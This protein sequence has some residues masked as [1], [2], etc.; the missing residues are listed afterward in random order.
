VST[1]DIAARS[2]AVLRQLNSRAVL[3]VLKRS[4]APLRVAEIMKVTNLSRPT[5]ETVT[6]GLLDQGWLTVD[7]PQRISDGRAGRPARRYSFNA[8]AGHVIGVDIGAHSVAVSLAG[9]RGD[10]IRTIR[11]PVSPN[12]SARQRVTATADAVGEILE[13]TKVHSDT[14]FA[15]TVGTPGTVSPSNQRVGKSP[16][17]PG[18]SETDLIA[19][20][21]DLA[22]FDIELEND[23]NLAAV[24]ERARGIGQGC[25]NM[26]FLLL[27]QRLGAGVIA[28]GA[29]IRGRDGAAGELGYAPAARARAR[30]AG[31][32]PLESLVN[33]RALVELGQRAIA[34][35]PNSRLA[36]LCG[37]DPDQLTAEAITLAAAEGDAAATRVL[38]TLV[39][40]LAQGIAPALLTLNPEVLVLGGGRSRA[41]EVLRDSLRSEINE[42]VLYPP[43]IRTSAL[44]DEAVLV[45]ALDESIKRV[46][47]NVL[48]KVSA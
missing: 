15:V 8:T 22:N 13:I 33:A 16:G 47:L 23:A 37:H 43:E 19:A 40:A 20:L 29:L 42:L 9:L 38:R 41:G 7:E 18:W 27:G 25:E 12:V 2:S 5:V 4:D 32:G 14:V 31:Y 1:A 45:G 6:E 34:R 36:D 10:I 46:E 21:R 48:S 11:R 35:N 28:N 17:M 3:D 44:G 26:L 24:G 30:P 39:R